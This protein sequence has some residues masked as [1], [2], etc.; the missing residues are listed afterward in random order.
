METYSQYDFNPPTP[1]GVGPAARAPA[2]VDSP[3]SIHPPRAG[4][5]NYA[6]IAGNDGDGISIHPPRAGWDYNMRGI[7]CQA[8]DFNPPTPCGV[9]PEKS[10]FFRT[11]ATFQSTHP[12]RG[13]TGQAAKAIV[14]RSNFNPPTPGGVGHIMR[15][16]GCQALD[17]NPPTPCGVGRR[18]RW[19]FLSHRCDFNPPPPC[20]VGRPLIKALRRQR[21]FQSTHPVRGGT[22]SATL[23]AL[24]YVISIHPP[25]AGWDLQNTILHLQMY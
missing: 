13:G 19:R 6:T 23:T 18:V 17:F 14:G 10:G 25:R 4:W 11:G 7:G 15:G 5:D 24:G 12:V 1:C 2:R 9:G 22:F 8:L 16:I 3:I 21:P 20:G